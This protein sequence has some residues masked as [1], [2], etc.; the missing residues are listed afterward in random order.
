M[1]KRAGGDRK[2]LFGK[3]CKDSTMFKGIV[4]I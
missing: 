1:M 4:H 2:N 3:E